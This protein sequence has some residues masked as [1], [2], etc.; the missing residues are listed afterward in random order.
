YT[1]NQ[2]KAHAKEFMKKLKDF[3][4]EE[5][6][7]TAGYPAESGE[8]TLSLLKLATEHENAEHDEIYKNF[9]EVAEKEGFKDI[10]ILFEKIASIEKVHA[11]RFAKYAKELE[12]NSL[13]KNETKMQWMCTNCGYIY[14]GNGAPEACPV[15]LHP[16]GFF[17]EFENTPFE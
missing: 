3:S 9:A 15:C 7:I 17:M 8:N 6:V 10:A 12:N 11:N 16:K 1:A 2:E 14:E 5:I 4:G 13:F